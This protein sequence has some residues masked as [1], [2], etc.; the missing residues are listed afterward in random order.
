MRASIR[1]LSA[2][3]QS[4]LAAESGALTRTERIQNDEAATDAGL[5]GPVVRAR[6]GEARSAEQ[7]GRWEDAIHAWNT[8]IDLLGGDVDLDTQLR[9]VR[10]CR[11]AGRYD[12]ANSTL[13]DLDRR[14]PGNPRVTSERGYIAIAQRDWK[15]ADALFRALTDGQNPPGTS[16]AYVAHARALR[17]LGR[18]SEALKLLARTAPG[19]GDFR[20]HE[21]LAL[22]AADVGDTEL[23]VREWKRT[24]DAL[25]DDPT[26]NRRRAVALHQLAVCHEARGDHAAAASVRVLHH[27]LASEIAAVDLGDWLD[28]HV[29]LTDED[30]AAA[31]AIVAGLSHRPHFS[32]LMPVHEPHPTHLADAIRSV[33]RQLYPDF[34]LVIVD[35]A[36]QRVD[37]GAVVRHVA[38]SDPRVLFSTRQVNG[39]I[40]TATNDALAQASGDW[41]V[42]LDQ[43]DLLTE[44]ALLE[45]AVALDGGTAPALVYSD[46][47]LIDEQG[48]CHG[49]QFKP[50]WD[51][52]LILGVNYVNHLAAFPRTAVDAVGGYRPECDGSQDWDLVLRLRDASPDAPVIHIPRVLYFWRASPTSFSATRISRAR[53]G[54]QLAV[55]DHLRRAGVD[56]SLHPVGSSTLLDVV[57]HIDRWPPVSVIIPTRDAPE[58]LGRCIDSLIAGTDY[59]DLELVLVDN[60]TTDA[61][62]LAIIE[63]VQQQ[64][65]GRAIRD[66]R[67]FNFSSLVN[68]GVEAARGQIAVLLNNDTEVVHPEW[69]RRLVAQA[70]RPDVGAVGAKLTYPSGTIQHAGVAFG[71]EDANGLG[72]LAGHTYRFHP[73]TD[74][75]NL[76]RLALSHTVSAVTAACMAIRRSA[77]LEVGGFDADNLPIAFNDVDFCIRLSMA[78]YRNIME[79]NARLVHHESATREVIEDERSRREKRYLRARWGPVLDADPYFN[80][81]YSRSSTS[82]TP[83]EA[84]PVSRA[85][86]RHPRP[87]G[88]REATSP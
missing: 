50:A 2:R 8:V 57:R 27:Q 63:R 28:R 33:T 25:G 3:V 68:A 32:V 59:P 11:R 73:D 58:L 17:G 18:S 22:L 51:P 81:N 48:R 79:P 39:G 40:A 75:G 46:E 42:P 41:V 10:A 29:T 78:G 72:R 26:L 38:G 30:R 7:D 34:E 65:Q 76:G 62:A 74:V 44:D 52:D 64:R 37:V 24:I 9:R 55:S 45:V 23:A 4:R 35:D 47:A 43:D 77:F 54:A 36:S 71:F 15:R 60:G 82:F 20:H 13:M 21:M 83:A 49:L 31:A 53:L 19:H 56:A 5:A 88:Q 66:G 12:E 1:R 61:D 87:R 84:S 67:Q 70:M 80:P 14:F 86:F 16:G 69:L 85:V 6:I